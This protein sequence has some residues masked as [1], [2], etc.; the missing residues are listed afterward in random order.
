MQKILKKKNVYTLPIKRMFTKLCLHPF[1]EVRWVQRDAAVGG[2]KVFEQKGVEFPDFWSLHAVNITVSKYFRGKLGTPEREKSLKQLLSRVTQTIRR[3]GEEGGYFAGAAQAR[4]FE[5]ELMH[6]L[7]HQKGSFN[8]PVWFNVGIKEHPQCSACFI[9][10]VEDTMPSILDWI[11]TEGMIFKGGSGAGVSLSNLRSRKEQLSVGGYASGPVSFMRGADSVAGMIKSG[12][13]TRRAAKM[14]VLGIDHPDVM[15][16]IRSKADEEKKIR[17]L[18]EA[19]YNMSDLNNEAWNSIQFQNANNSVRLTDEFMRAV[20]EDEEWKTKYIQNGKP[21]DTYK[22]RTLLGDIAEAAWECGDPGVQFDTII[23][24][25]HTCPNTGRINASNPCSEYMHLDNSACNLASI[26]L[27]K[28]LREDGTFDV[29]GFKH[30]VD[31]FILAQ[32]IIVGRSS[33]P[34]EL[35]TKNAIAFRELG[36][37]FSNLGALLMT[38]GIAYDSEEARAWAGSISSLMSGEA[39]RYSA[40]IARRMKPFS[41]Y[42]K[43]RAPMLEVIKQHGLEAGKIKSGHVDDTKLAKEAQ[44]VWDEA[45]ATGTAYGFRNSQATVIAPTGTISFMMDCDTTGIEPD[46][47][48]IK[49]KQLVGGGWMKI[50]NASVEESLRRLGYT[51]SEAKDIVAYIAEQG[52]VEGAPKFKEKHLS[53]FDCAVR[54]EKGTRSISWK[55]HV[56]MVGAVQP[57]ISGAISKT[58]NMPHDVTKKEIEEAYVMAWKLG[59]KAFAVYRDGSKAAQPL[60]TSGNTSKDTKG[61]AQAKGI[62]RRRLP[63]TRMSQTHKFVIAGHEGYL[64]YSTYEDGTLAETFIRMAKQGSTLSGLLDAFAISVS[65]ALQYGV[66]LKALAHKFIHS[67]FEPAG[68]TENPDIRIATSIVD[69]IFRY[70]ALT[71]LSAEDLFE[72]GMGPKLLTEQAPEGKVVQKEEREKAPVTATLMSVPKKNV[73]Q[74]GTVCRNCGGMMV[75]TG[76]CMTCLQCGGSSGGCS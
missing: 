37:G 4:T 73:V 47:S 8:S 64:T 10:A 69:Y 22:A 61:S 21:A 29:E 36:L 71:F 6:V 13:S 20:E 34:T 75:R 55:G 53:I 42:A 35:I 25:W 76:T 60:S 43:N 74:A 67:R 1:D 32:E 24:K 11:R 27:M 50:V 52:T 19:G 54:P 57:F 5:D 46:F 33:Y 63:A 70:L 41:G 3:W 26:N 18:I 65:M 58:F 49:M 66:P 9:L 59:I 40:E 31:I 2:S 17:A 39:Y 12:G 51:K 7:V 30:T 16:F 44:G 68:F 45:L 62:A 15:D 23:N 72:F 48:L 38:K 28:F 56:R 14:V